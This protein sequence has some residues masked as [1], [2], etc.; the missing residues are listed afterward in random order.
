MERTALKQR[1]PQPIG[2]HQ[3][4]SA[5]VRWQI[6]RNE[7]KFSCEDIEHERPNSSTL[8]YSFNQ[9]FS[10]DEGYQ[11]TKERTL[12]V[13]TFSK[14]V[15]VLWSYETQPSVVTTE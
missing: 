1:Q 7:D 3:K 5:S 2:L 12:Y 15:S 13:R 11:S 14:A 9:R 4:G 8:R 6:P 10:D